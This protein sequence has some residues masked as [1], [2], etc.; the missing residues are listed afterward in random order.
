M[1]IRDKSIGTE[2]MDRALSWLESHNAD[3]LIVEVA[4]GNEAAYEFYAKY[5]FYPRLTTLKRKGLLSALS[6]SIQG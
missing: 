2:L 5:G 4:V 6:G 3:T 1:N